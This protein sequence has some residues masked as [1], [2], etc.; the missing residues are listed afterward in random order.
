MADYTT[1]QAAATA[2][3]AK[4]LTGS[5]V[6]LWGGDPAR[7][8]AAN[9]DVFILES[10]YRVDVKGSEVRIYAPKED[11]TYERKTRIWGDPHV[12]EGGGGAIRLHG[13]HEVTGLIGDRLQRRAR[14]LRAPA[15]PRETENRHTSL[16][17]HHDLDAH[18]R[19]AERFEEGRRGLLD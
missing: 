18:Q 3:N 7:T 17:S 15:V 5:G 6:R 11:G 8:P 10:G 1:A 4:A 16:I 14:D 19:Y 13:H 2:A 12:N 9:G